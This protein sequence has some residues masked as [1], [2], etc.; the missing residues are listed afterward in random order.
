MDRITREDC[1][2]IAATI[3]EAL[4]G[5]RIEVQGRNGYFGVDLYD[6]HGMVDT[7]HLGSKREIYTY[8]QGMRRTLLI[9]GR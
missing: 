5:L 6:A 9:I 8:M 4:N 3:S 7:L 1:D 2:R